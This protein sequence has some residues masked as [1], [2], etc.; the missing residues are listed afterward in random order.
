MGLGT[1]PSYPQT[2][3]RLHRGIAAAL[4]TAFCIAIVVGQTGTAS[5]ASGGAGVELRP[6]ITKVICAK[7]CAGK[8]RNRVARGGSTIRIKGDDLNIASKVIFL[9]GP[10]SRDDT[11]ARVRTGNRKRAL[12]KVPADSASGRIV[13]VTANGIKSKASQY[14]TVLPQPPVI[15]TPELK[16]VPTGNR[17]IS[18]QAGTST[19]R[20]VYLGAKEL[21]RYSLK[22]SGVDG[23]KVSI[24]LTRLSSGETA[25]AWTIPAP[26]GQVVSVDWNGEIGNQPASPGRY[27]FT[28]AIN[29]DLVALSSVKPS[30][31][32]EARDAFDLHGFMFPV[33]GR[34]NYGRRGARF[35]G[36]R[37][38]QGQ[39]LMA[40]C[41]TKLVAAR[42]GTVVESRFQSAAGNFIVIRPD[43]AEIGD[44]AYMHMPRRS[45]FR[46]GDRVYTGQQIGQVGSTGRS[47][48]CHLHF[49][50]W[51]G[52]IWRSRPIDP[53]PS[54]RA[55]SLVR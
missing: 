12:V 16:P 17:S 21:V 47:S 52:A 23:A 46:K 7:K 27:A 43:S 19:P 20:K 54:L 18:L 53:L 33:R 44:Q 39:D 6:K 38:H 36:G 13:A 42:G 14:F 24:A 35:G 26:N 15:G 48:A 25:A 34:Y 1:L 2:S 9:G 10:G 22:L 50:Q 40:R 55:W 28:V 32:V 11:V 31:V 45:P 49:E 41:G 37:G 5:A 51:T 30:S 8:K 4:A 29:T 3:Y